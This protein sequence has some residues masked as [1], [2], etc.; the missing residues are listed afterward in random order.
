VALESRFEG[1]LR[2]ALQSGRGALFEAPG[3]G[4]L[5]EKAIKSAKAN[6]QPAE[7]EEVLSGAFFWLT[8]FYFVYC[9]RLGD[10]IPGLSIIPLAKISGALATI[11][12]FLTIGK[13]SRQISDIP[14]EAYYLAGMIVLLFASAVF[15]PVW[16][17]G[18][19]STVLDFSKVLVAWLMTFLLVT[20]LKRFRR[21]IF[22]QSASVAVISAVAIAKGYSI[23][24]ME[25]V[26]SGLYSNPNDMSFA[27]VLSLPFCLT[28]L[29]LAKN[30][31][32][33]TVWGFAILV[34]M[35]ALML[36]ASRA[37]FINLII[38]GAVLLWQFGIKGKR[39]YL[40]V[41][42]VALS[43]I[44]FLV[45]GKSLTVRLNG[46]FNS[47][48]RD[49]EQDSAHASYEQR[50]QLMIKARDTIIRY[51]IF[52]VGA[53]DFKAYAG[54][55]RDVHVAYLQIAVEGGIPVLILYLLFFGRGF[56]NLKFL[57]RQDLDDETVLFVGALKSS[58]VGFVVGACFAPEAYQYFPYFAVCYTSVLVAMA[59][60][61]AP[62]ELP[63]A[64]LLS[65]PLRSLARVY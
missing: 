15:S 48:A 18:A 10:L 37:A 39:S 41:A 5:S 3:S 60:E 1:Q 17:G 51:P 4:R 50:R 20:S 62:S 31:L 28:F 6:A 47:G 13:T 14:K 25:G 35:A 30:W 54:N 52:G 27:I 53:N 42:A 33:K 7:G 16:K 65:P 12:L 21:I 56:A 43:W 8:A 23:P 2:S 34:M 9:G 45:A 38:A 24:R 61:R 22:V 46:M 63:A 40:I 57:S 58:L 64:R 11:S 49:S 59:K 19:V 55:W 32:R 44:L 29:L 26:I 36:S